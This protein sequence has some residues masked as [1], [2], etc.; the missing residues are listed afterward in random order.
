MQLT[1][2]QKEELV[3][4]IK[5]KLDKSSSMVIWNHDSLSV[6]RF[7]NLRQMLKDNGCDTKVY[8]NTLA[9]IA[10]KEKGYS[11]FDDG[12]NG[13]SSVAFSYDENVNVSKLIFDELKKDKKETVLRAGIVAGE[14][15]DID[16][17]KV[18]ATLPSRNELLG[19]LASVL[20]APIRNMAYLTSQVAE[21]K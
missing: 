7:N 1:R 3:A 9:K 19:M 8:K 11:Q 12:F 16:G 10:L 6:D 13:V 4:E 17:I 2:K 20:Q 21:Q 5:D 14:Y 18:I 15:Q